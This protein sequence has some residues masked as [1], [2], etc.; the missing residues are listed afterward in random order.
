M[1]RAKNSSSRVAGDE[2]SDVTSSTS[3]SV[4]SIT[5]STSWNSRRNAN[6]KQDVAPLIED[7][8]EQ[9]DEVVEEEEEEEA[10]QPRRRGRPPKKPAASAP[11]AKKPAAKR[12]SRKAVEQPLEEEEEEEEEAQE[13][14]EEVVADDD[15]YFEDSEEDDADTHSM[16]PYEEVFYRRGRGHAKNDD[17]L[18]YMDPANRKVSTLQYADQAEHYTNDMLE[19]LSRSIRRQPSLADKCYAFLHAGIPNRIRQQWIS[20]I[21][22]LLLALFILATIVLCPL[23]HLHQVD[24]SPRANNVEKDQ[25]VPPMFDA[26]FDLP[27]TQHNHTSFKENWARFAIVGTSNHLCG[28]YSS[29]PILDAMLPGDEM[30]NMRLFGSAVLS[31]LI[32][33]IIWLISVR[34]EERD[35]ILGSSALVQG[36][37]AFFTIVIIPVASA[38]F[39]GSVI[40][41]MTEDSFLQR[42]PAP[43]SPNDTLRCVTRVTGI[44]QELATFAPIRELVVGAAC[45]AVRFTTKFCRLP[46][47]ALSLHHPTGLSDKSMNTISLMW[48]FLVGI[49]CYNF[50]SLVRAIYRVFRDNNRLASDRTRTAQ[51]EKGLLVSPAYLPEVIVTQNF[52]ATMILLLVAFF[53]WIVGVPF[54]RVHEGEVFYVFLA[55]VP[56]LNAIHSILLIN[57]KKRTIPFAPKHYSKKSKYMPVEDT[58]SSSTSN[59]H[60]HLHDVEFD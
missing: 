9:E 43:V 2:D 42:T 13:M 54:W 24:I 1:A 59:H 20:I 25:V 47:E 34:L 38:A 60:D 15:D 14:N 26:T 51:H 6:N 33:F 11:S 36:L 40:V 56:V 53:L 55:L 35:I 27:I 58:P 19:Q 37:Y 23:P 12:Q 5:R 52:F 29:Q 30:R 22:S 31:G 8:D 48:R 39:L 4:S 3:T 16:P 21:V 45:L 49:A 41:Y 17:D 57:R 18:A 28:R 7:V 32:L 10:P 46:I 44:N 50:L